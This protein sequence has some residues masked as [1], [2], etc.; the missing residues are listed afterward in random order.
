MTTNQSACTAELVSADKKIK[1]VVT[2]LGYQFPDASGDSDANWY[3]TRFEYFT[4]NSTYTYTTCALDAGSML[5]CACTM[6][7]WKRSLQNEDGI[8][9]VP[10]G[11][12][13]E[14]KAIKKRG[15]ILTFKKRSRRFFDRSRDG[16]FLEG[17]V[18]EINFSFKVDRVIIKRFTD[19]A[20]LISEAYPLR[21]R[22]GHRRIE[23][24]PVKALDEKF[25][26]FKLSEPH[27]LLL[28]KIVE[29]DII[30]A[31][32]P[33]DRVLRRRT[34]RLSRASRINKTTAFEEYEGLKSA[35]LSRLRKDVL[36]N[37]RSY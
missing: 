15:P 12:S 29:D 28:S 25:N 2:V 35:A 10:Y 34:R 22:R 24:N 37:W 33:I 16:I 13:V 19:G 9:S 11:Q 32:E 27:S 7:N 14:L 30:R 6:T 31:F 1:L 8:L 23:F 4:P 18:G 26:G 17:R 5:S 21:Y 20:R 36:A 3:K